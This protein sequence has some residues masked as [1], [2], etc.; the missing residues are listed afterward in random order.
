[1]PDSYEIVVRLTKPDLPASQRREAL[2]KFAD[3]NRWVPSDEIEDYPGTEGFTNGHLVVE[4][5]LSNTAVISFL[6]SNHPY[7]TL[8][9]EEKLK[10]LAISYNNLVEWH[11]FPDL[12]GLTRVF[13]RVKSLKEGT[14]Y[15]SLSQHEDAWRAEAFDRI[16]GRRPNPNIDACVKSVL[17]KKNIITHC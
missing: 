5:G 2:K 16:S 9:E 1:M 7:G 13:N 4:H 14:E 8:T 15:I 17:G 12:N 10:I 11:L 3:E 6:K